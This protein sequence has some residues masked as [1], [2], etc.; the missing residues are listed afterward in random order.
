MPRS[1]NKIFSSIVKHVR[2]GNKFAVKRLFNKLEEIKTDE[3]ATEELTMQTAALDSKYDTN[4]ALNYTNKKP[5]FSRRC[6]Y[7]AARA[8]VGNTKPK[9]RSHLPSSKYRAL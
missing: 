1:Y 3:D 8:G 6:N 2:N 9:T 7:T 5:V 4:T